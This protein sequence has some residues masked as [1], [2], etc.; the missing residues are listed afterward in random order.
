LVEL[1]FRILGGVKHGKKLNGPSGLEFRPTT[2]RVKSFIFSFFQQDI[3]GSRMLDL[4]SGTGSFGLEA[5][6]RGARECVCVEKNDG[7]IRLLKANADA[8]GFGNRIRIVAVDVFW[9]LDMF[10]RQKTAF[11]FILADPPFKDALRERIVNAVDKQ[12]V[13]AQNGYLIVE[14]DWRDPDSMNHGMKL[15]KQKRFGHCMVSI[16]GYLDFSS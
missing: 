1:V 2:G 4:F 12:G 5:V 11:D 7:A 9:A 14:H 16:Y 3:D 6:S 13:L 10:A 15:L 8:C